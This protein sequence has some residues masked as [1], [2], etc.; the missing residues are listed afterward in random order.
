M[1]ARPPRSGSLGGPHLVVQAVEHVPQ[2]IGI[3]EYTAAVKR[4][5]SSG[6]LRRQR[7]DLLEEAINGPSYEFA[8]G[9][10]LLSGHSSKPF[11]H[12]IGKEDLNLLHGSML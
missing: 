8:H 9:A 5:K 11:H 4:G 6:L 1:S 2:S 12:R 7:R 10:I 3:H